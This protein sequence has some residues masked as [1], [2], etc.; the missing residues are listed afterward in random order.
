M[1]MD[2]I[3]NQEISVGLALA[4]TLI[5]IL[6]CKYSV[7]SQEGWASGIN[8]KDKIKMKIVWNGILKTWCQH[9]GI[10]KKNSND[11]QKSQIG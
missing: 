11:G 3:K 6:I 7:N 10:K 8:L 9:L 4:K 5:H 1:I 2:A